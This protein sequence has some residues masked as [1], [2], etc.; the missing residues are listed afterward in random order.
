MAGEDHN[1]SDNFGPHKDEQPALEGTDIEEHIIELVGKSLDT[2]S[3]I[4]DILSGR[5]LQDG[6]LGSKLSSFLRE[7][8]FSDQEFAASISVSNIKYNHPRFLI[9]NPFYL[10]H[11]QLDNTLAYKS[12]ESMTTKG[13]VDKFLSESLMTPLIKRLSY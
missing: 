8:R 6:L 9:N 1:L 7:I 10:F 13:N 4:K 5:T 12:A 2:E 3:H 11:D